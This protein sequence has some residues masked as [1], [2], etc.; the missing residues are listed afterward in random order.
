MVAAVVAATRE[1]TNLYRKNVLLEQKNEEQAAQ[2]LEERS[3][4]RSLKQSWKEHLQICP[5][6]GSIQ[7]AGGED[8]DH[9]LEVKKAKSLHHL[10]Q[11][12]DEQLSGFIEDK[13]VDAMELISRLRLIQHVMMRL[14]ESLVKGSFL[15]GLFDHNACAMM[16]CEA[17]ILVQVQ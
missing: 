11:K 7:L 4:I 16:D 17:V 3:R 13:T 8:S 14:C 6:S 9:R 2:L 5:L 12:V 10:F 15:E 1:L